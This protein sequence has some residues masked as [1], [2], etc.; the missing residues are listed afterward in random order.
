MKNK[1]LLLL[2]ALF[3]TFLFTNCSDDDEDKESKSYIGSWR[4]DA[5]ESSPGSGMYNLTEFTFESTS[6]TSETYVVPDPSN[7]AVKVPAIGVKGTY[8]DEGNNTL[9]VS[10][11]KLG[12][13]NEAGAFDYMDRTDDATEFTQ[14]YVGSGMQA[15]MPLDFDA[16]YAMDGSSKMDLIIPE[17][18][19]NA[20][21]TLR[22]KKK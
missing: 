17:T 20:S 19:T 8:T 22:L 16:T 10:I 13:A 5:Y 12:P 7:I 4:T 1:N 6:F 3:A 9:K 11:T 18:Q 15:A 2:V 21:D 14:F